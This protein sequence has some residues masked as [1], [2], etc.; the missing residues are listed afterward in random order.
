MILHHLYIA[1]CANSHPVGFCSHCCKDYDIINKNFVFYWQGSPG[2]RG[3]QGEQ[4]EPGPKVS[5][6]AQHHHWPPLQGVS[7]AGC[8][9]GCAQ[10]WCELGSLGWELPHC[11]TEP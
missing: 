9:A 4:G 5:P 2:R 11:S 1:K 3:P 10:S 8:A 7:E 6:G